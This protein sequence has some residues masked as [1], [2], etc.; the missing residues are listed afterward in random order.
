MPKKYQMSWEGS[1][2][3]RWVKMFKGKRHKVSCKELG[4]PKTKIESYQA[5]NDWWSKT[6]AELTVRKYEPEQAEK[7]ANLKIKMDYA[8]NNAPELLADLKA[9]EKQIQESLPSDADLISDDHD[10][11]QENLQIAEMVGITVPEDTDPTV[12]QQLFGERRVWQDRL[13]N[14]STT[15]NNKTVGY[16]LGEFIEENSRKKP[17]TFGEIQQYLDMTLD[18]PIWSR[19]TSIDTI[20]TE[21]VRRFIKWLNAKEYEPSTHNKVLGFFRRFVSWLD[22][23]ELIEKAPKN[24]RLKEQRKKE[25]HKEV[26]KYENVKEVIESLPMPKKLWALLG[27]NCSMTQDDLGIFRWDWIKKAIRAADSGDYASLIDL[28]RRF[29]DDPE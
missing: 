25:V 6:V 23:H 8:A 14:H 24:L 3:F 21:T 20:D 7:L 4:M 26:K 28:H 22:N 1:P 18:T 19:E 5:A 13:K 9:T 12:I 15:V 11:I 27:C 16:Q 29:S 10:T 2:A 17:Q